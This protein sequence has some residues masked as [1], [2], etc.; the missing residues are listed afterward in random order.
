MHDRRVALPLQTN[1]GFDPGCL[2]AICHFGRFRQMR[3]QGPLAANGFLGGKRGID[4]LLVQRHAHNDGDEVDI[5]M[6][7]HFVHVMEGEVGTELL[8]G[9]LGGFFMR[10]TDGFQLIARQ[11]LQCRHMGVR[12]PATAAGCHSRT[13]NSYP[14]FICHVRFLCFS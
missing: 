3:P 1:Q 12:T 14:D 7:D 4:E 11:G 9:G 13:N 6:R 5:G 8:G 10:G 2:G